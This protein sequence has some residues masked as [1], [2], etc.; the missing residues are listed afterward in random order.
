MQLDYDLVK[1]LE[2]WVGGT[3]RITDDFYRFKLFTEKGQ[4]A[5]YH[6]TGKMIPLMT[7][8]KLTEEE[9]NDLRALLWNGGGEKLSGLYGS[10]RVKAFT[11]EH[12][13]N[14]RYEDAVATPEELDYEY[15]WSDL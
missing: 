4:L 1:G 8:I 15:G 9:F 6:L 7:N 12:F 3:Y 10:Y 5:M 14:K 11:D 2:E 13:Y